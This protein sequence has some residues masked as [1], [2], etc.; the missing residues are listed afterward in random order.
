MQ[1][2]PTQPRN[3]VRVWV[4]GLSKLLS[5]ENSCEWAVWFRARNWYERLPSGFDLD[6]WNQEHNEL[7][8]FRSKQLAEEGYSVT[9]EIENSFSL[10]GTRSGAS[11]AGKPD[12]IAIKDGSVVFE[13]CKTGKKRLADHVQVALYMLLSQYQPIFK[14][15]PVSGRVIYKD[16][17][18][19]LDESVCVG[20]LDRLGA[21][22]TR[23]SALTPPSKAP[24]L[25]ECGYCDISDFYCDSRLNSGNNRVYVTDL[26]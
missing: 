25:N 18:V 19:S 14:S 15:R 26:F 12:I 8:Q 23:L 10:R 9:L 2:T 21:L 3:E 4:S 6:R 11:I 20:L 5:G 7:V 16:G 13:D 1:F 24:S 17:P 22:V